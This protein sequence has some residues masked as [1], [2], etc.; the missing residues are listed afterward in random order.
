MTGK[1]GVPNT[2]FYRLLETGKECEE[3][4][5]LFGAMRNAPMD[6]QHPVRFPDAKMDDIL[7]GIESFVID[8]EKRG[9]MTTQ[10]RERF[11]KALRSLQDRRDSHT[12]RRTN[13]D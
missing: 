11:E 13:R 10:A 12:A 3:W 2:Q 6:M 7:D 8:E 5:D 4:I 9:G 1:D